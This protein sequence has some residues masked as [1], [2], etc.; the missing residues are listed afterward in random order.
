MDTVWSGLTVSGA[1]ETELTMKTKIDTGGYDTDIRVFVKAG[2][3]GNASI[4]PQMWDQT[5]GD[6]M[7]V[8]APDVHLGVPLPSDLTMRITLDAIAPGDWQLDFFYDIGAGFVLAGTITDEDLGVSTFIDLST[9]ALRQELYQYTHGVATN[10]A[11]LD[12]WSIVPEPATMCLLGLGGL[13]LR[14]RK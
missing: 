13:M 14:R 4:Y 3:G 11:S 9:Q 8:I 1:G 7:S 12:N 5:G 2:P 6:K 10:T